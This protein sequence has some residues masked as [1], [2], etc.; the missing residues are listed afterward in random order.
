MEEATRVALGALVV[1]GVL[2]TIQNRP[3][4]SWI[5]LRGRYPIYRS[6]MGLSGRSL[7]QKTVRIQ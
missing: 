2:L 4:G 5:R 7:S 6:G 1:V 3:Y